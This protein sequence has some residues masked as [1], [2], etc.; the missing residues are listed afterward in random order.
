[1]R[2][3]EL[4]IEACVVDL[5]LVKRLNLIKSVEL[6]IEVIILFVFGHGHDKLSLHHKDKL[7]N[8][9]DHL[10]GGLMLS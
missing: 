8:R 5:H 7:H 1:M 6:Q 10:A 4:N 2:L 3:C 9:R